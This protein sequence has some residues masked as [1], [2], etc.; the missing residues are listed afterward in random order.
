MSQI[1]WKFPNTLELSGKILNALSWK[2]YH[3]LTLQQAVWLYLTYFHGSITTGSLFSQLS[4]YTWHTF[5]EA[6]PQ[7][8]SLA[9]CLVTLD[10]LIHNI[11]ITEMGWRQHRI[12]R[13]TWWSGPFCS[14]CEGRQ[15][16]WDWFPRPVPRPGRVYQV[17]GLTPVASMLQTSSICWLCTAPSQV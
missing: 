11:S 7:A 16:L 6:V 17:C 15:W 3:R 5:M 1:G 4:G 14:S 8:H 10:L 9:S 13:I 12:K 2:H